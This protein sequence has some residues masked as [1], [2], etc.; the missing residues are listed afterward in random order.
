[1]RLRIATLAAILGVLSASPS[2]AGHHLWDLTEIYSNGDGSVQFVE[3]FTAAA[4]EQGVGPFTVTASGH[5]FNFVT[6]LSTT[7]TA[8]TWILMATANFA[9]QT[10]GVTPD[11]II[12]ANFFNTGGGTM[13]YAG[14]VD[15][16]NYGAVP[17][18]GVHSLLRSGSIAVNSPENFAHQ[19][20]SVNLGVSLPAFPSWALILLCGALL[21]AASSFLRRREMMTA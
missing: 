12:P 2:F 7:A 18:D 15:V 17:T 11:Y 5:T 3:L 4:N 19:T 8:N 16:W 20:G 9:S 10:G 1:M 14:A 13:A 6:N 21:F